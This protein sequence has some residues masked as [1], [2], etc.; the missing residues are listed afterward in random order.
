MRSKRLSTLRLA[1]TLL[2]PFKLVCWL[3]IQIS[4][5]KKSD[6]YTKPRGALQLKKT[7]PDNP[8]RPLLFSLIQAGRGADCRRRQNE[9][10]PF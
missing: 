2:L 5:V 3:M 8:F 9:A 7:A 1:E 10:A 4:P 6:K